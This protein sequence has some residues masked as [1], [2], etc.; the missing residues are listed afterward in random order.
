MPQNLM[1]CV[2]IRQPPPGTPNSVYRLYTLFNF[3]HVN[4]LLLERDEM[5]V[6]HAFRDQQ[7][8]NCQTSSS[9][10]G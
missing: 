4:L 5:G 6:S 10:A 3:C 7:Y 1:I 2:D 9:V 8:Y